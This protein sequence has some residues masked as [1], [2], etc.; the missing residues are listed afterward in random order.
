M[1]REFNRTDRVAEQLQR[2]LAQII[3]ME[4]KDPRLGMVT[5]SAVEISRDLY[6][7]TAYVTFLG[8]DEDEKS[9]RQALE[10]L[11]QASGFIRSLIG[12]RMK[13]RVIP[14]LKFEFDGSI[15]RGSELSALINK[16]REK[17]ADLSEDKSDTQ[18]DS[19]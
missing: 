18:D 16:A 7:S 14:Q 8:I 5:V 10:V 3:Q 9:I 19:E 17:D 6:Y 4:I 11:N 12:K 15:A 2:E 13:L 1:A